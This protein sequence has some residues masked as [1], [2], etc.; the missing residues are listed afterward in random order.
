MIYHIS[1]IEDEFHCGASRHHPRPTLFI[2]LFFLFRGLYVVEHKHAEADE[3][4]GD[5][6]VDE[7][8]G[9]FLRGFCLLLREKVDFA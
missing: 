6:E 2:E 5:K 8:H 7:L 3:N 4:K 1:L 9:A